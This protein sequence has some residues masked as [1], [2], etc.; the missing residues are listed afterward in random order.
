MVR[1]KERWLTIAAWNGIIRLAVAVRVAV[2]F[3]Q[4]IANNPMAAP[5]LM[6]T[7]AYLCTNAA[8]AVLLLG[9]VLYDTDANP[10]SHYVL[11]FFYTV[12]IY[13]HRQAFRD[14]L[15][16]VRT[17]AEAL[18]Y[19]CSVWCASAGFWLT[20]FIALGFIWCVILPSSWS[21]TC[22]GLLELLL[23]ASD[24]AA[25]FNAETLLPDFWP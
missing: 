14:A 9:I 7:A 24:N 25:V 20:L 17:P 5:A 15:E 8:A 1:A 2:E 11:V 16:L 3:H 23:A 10:L 6:R 4:R 22:V 19:T 21:E 12:A 13:E 18:N